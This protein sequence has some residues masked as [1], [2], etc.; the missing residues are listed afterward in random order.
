[1]VDKVL[2]FNCKKIKTRYNLI[3]FVN[4]VVRE[5]SQK[6]SQEK[7]I[8]YLID[9]YK[10]TKN[11]TNNCITDNS[12]YEKLVDY[13]ELFSNAPVQYFNN[14]VVGKDKEKTF[15]A[16][17]NR[18]WNKKI[19]VEKMTDKELGFGI[20]IFRGNALLVKMDDEIIK[21]NLKDI[22]LKKIANDNF[23]DFYYS[24]FR[25]C[26]TPKEILD[27]YKYFVKLSNVIIQ[28]ERMTSY[29]PRIKE[30]VIG[31]YP[32]YIGKISSLLSTEEKIK[33]LSCDNIPTSCINEEIVKK[34][35]LNGNITYNFLLEAQ[36]KHFWDE[37]ML[38][39]FC[40]NDFE[41][42]SLLFNFITLRKKKVIAYPKLLKKFYEIDRRI[43]AKIDYA[44]KPD[45]ICIEEIKYLEGV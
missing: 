8:Q 26:F 16:Y 5:Y 36:K 37:E 20:K 27:N 15:I 6:N 33:Y 32:K 1:M 24:Y 25:L 45:K 22:M 44:Y 31:K 23:N 2:E 41:H 35:I 40:K 10:Y 11:C 18:Q 21:R 9:N 17:I 19:N 39:F 28:E 30:I 34:V 38:I 14:F 42:F 4:D 7:L 13:P 3:L 43:F 29:L 12:L